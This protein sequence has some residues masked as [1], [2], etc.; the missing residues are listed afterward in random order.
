[1]PLHFCEGGSASQTNQF[2]SLSTRSQRNCS[3]L[4]P[5]LRTELAR[6][7]ALFIVLL[8]FPIFAMFIQTFRQSILPMKLFLSW[9]LKKNLVRPTIWSGP[10][11]DSGLS[12]LREKRTYATFIRLSLGCSRSSQRGK[13]W[14][15]KSTKCKNYSDLPRAN[16]TM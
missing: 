2:S 15:S 11:R 5:L 10:N 8:V 9:Q 7:K 16:S 14:A 13:E 4:L 12:G 6:N 3:Q 1:M